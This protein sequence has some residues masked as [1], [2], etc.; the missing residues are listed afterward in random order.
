MKVKQDLWIARNKNEALYLY[1]GKP[2]RCGD[3]MF[4]A[5]DDEDLMEL[6]SRLFP[7]VTFENSPQRVHIKR[8]KLQ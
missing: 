3:Y 1:D 6:D 8:I 5:L 2:L 7:D 4:R